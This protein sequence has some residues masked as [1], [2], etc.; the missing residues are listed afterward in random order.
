MQS[1]CYSLEIML[2]QLS[3]EVADLYKQETWSSEPMGDH[4][5]VTPLVIDYSELTSCIFKKMN[6]YNIT[7]LIYI[8]QPAKFETV[9]INACKVIKETLLQK[10][11]E[12]RPLLNSEEVKARMR[13]GMGNALAAFSDVSL[14]LK[15][16][17]KS[18]YDSTIQYNINVLYF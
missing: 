5:F 7:W 18:Y 17:I 14:E 1:R 2:H 13:E 11:N 15:L 12:E 3:T 10:Y 4:G 8:L 9:I 16:S 6:L